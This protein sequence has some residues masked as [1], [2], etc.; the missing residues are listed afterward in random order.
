MNNQIEQK[1]KSIITKLDGTLNKPSNSFLQNQERFYRIYKKLM[2][3]SIHCDTNVSAFELDEH[4]ETSPDSSKE[5]IETKSTLNKDENNNNSF[6]SNQSSFSSE[7]KKENEINIWNNKIDLDELL[8]ILDND[9]ND[10]YDNNFPDNN[11]NIENLN[12]PSNKN[13]AK[14]INENF[15][16]INN[17][18]FN[19]NLK[20]KFIKIE[21]ILKNYL[22]NKTK[23]SNN[24]INEN[25]TKNIYYGGFRHSLDISGIFSMSTK[26]KRNKNNNVQILPN[27]VTNFFEDKEALK[28]ELEE[29]NKRHSVVP[30]IEIKNYY[31]INSTSFKKLNKFNNFNSEEVKFK[32]KNNKDVSNFEQNSENSFV[33]GFDFLKVPKRTSLLPT[34]GNKIINI[35]EEFKEFD[36]FNDEE[37]SDDSNDENECDDNNNN[38]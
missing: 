20:N 15:E 7:K 19:E 6:I 2:S 13:D 22:E 8:N 23:N 37:I 28:K 33:E 36:S 21:Q 4:N 30:G 17:H 29:V 9:L 27:I 32:T 16:S 11:E 35:K 18:I 31:H 1:I 3:I 26:S 25:N 5:N 12:S 14:N 38:D 34:F 24:N 10:I